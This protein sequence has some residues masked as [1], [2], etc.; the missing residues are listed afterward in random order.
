ME[1]SFRI[2]TPNDS[3]EI[4]LDIT[5]VV[6]SD[7]FCSEEKVEGILISYFC[8]AVVVTDVKA[9]ADIR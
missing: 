4:L 9:Q 1:W 2:K 5:A 3:Y 6:G 7:T 8:I